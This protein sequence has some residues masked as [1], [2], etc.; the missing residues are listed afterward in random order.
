MKHNS[1][2]DPRQTRL[3]LLIWNQIDAFMFIYFLLDYCA[4]KKGFS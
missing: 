2:F 4:D 1:D 3:H